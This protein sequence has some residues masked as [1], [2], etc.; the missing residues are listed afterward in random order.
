MGVFAYTI[1]MCVAV[2]F[3]CCGCGCAC[4]CLCRCGLIVAEFVVLMIEVDGDRGPTGTSASRVFCTQNGLA[5]EMK[6]P[7]NDLFF[8]FAF[9]VIFLGRLLAAWGQ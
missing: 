5:W 8:S 1:V 4:V 7:P 2:V 6:R 9:A 3:H